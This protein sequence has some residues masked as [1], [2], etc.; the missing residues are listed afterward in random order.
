MSSKSLMA[1]TL[2]LFA[3]ALSGCY[4]AAEDVTTFERYYMTALNESSSAE[5]MMM[6]QDNEKELLTQS[7]NAVVSWG[8]RRKGYLMWFNAVAFD[9]DSSKAIRKYGFVANEKA[10]GFIVAKVQTMRFDAEVVINPDVLSEPYASENDRQIAILKSVLDDF[11][12]DFVELTPDSQ[13]L[14]SSALMVKQLLKGI[15]Y[16]LDHSPALAAKLSEYSG[17]EFD[18]VTLDKARVRM[19]VEGDIVKL[20]AMTGSTIRDFDRKLEI[21]VM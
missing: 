10:K 9:Q 18:H 3:V 2:V 14:E 15:L 5:V 1:L 21:I 4:K 8:E 20:K 6:I 19:I 11:S 16:Q 7:E 17:M 13:T 12:D